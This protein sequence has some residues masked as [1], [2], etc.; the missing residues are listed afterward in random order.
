[1]HFDTSAF[2][3]CLHWITYLP[4]TLD[5]YSFADVPVILGWKILYL[6]RKRRL[7]YYYVLAICVTSI[8]KQRLSACIIKYKHDSLVEDF[9]PLQN[10]LPLSVCFLTTSVRTWQSILPSLSL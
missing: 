2:V 9:K 7:F 10:V 4:V 3:C 6:V 8:I 5:V 1:M